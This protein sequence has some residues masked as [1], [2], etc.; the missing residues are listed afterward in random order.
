MNVTLS[1]SPGHGEMIV[2]PTITFGGIAN[3]LLMEKRLD[4]FKPGPFFTWSVHLDGSRVEHDASVCQAGVYDRAVAAIQEAK[5]RGF[6]VN[7]NCTLFDGADPTRVAAFF[8]EA[9]EAG[10]DGI[11]VSP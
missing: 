11:T 9:M 2:I 10:I 7:I 4:R 1:V 5:K 3:A 8:D 6:R